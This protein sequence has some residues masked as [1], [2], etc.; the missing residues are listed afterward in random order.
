LLDD[1]EPQ[2]VDWMDVL[3]EGVMM[4]LVTE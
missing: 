1:A 4:R 3:K 2:W